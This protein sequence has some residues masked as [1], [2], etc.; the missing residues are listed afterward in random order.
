[1]ACKGTNLAH[2]GKYSST[3]TGRLRAPASS[4]HYSLV[5]P[6]MSTIKTKC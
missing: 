2:K 5:R 4:N 6:H 3:G 1:M